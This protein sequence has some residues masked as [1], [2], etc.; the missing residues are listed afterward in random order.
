MASIGDMVARLGVDNSGFT[1]G[2][3]ASKSS[4]TSWAGSVTGIIAGAAGALAG[5]WSVGESVAS[6]RGALEA[7]QKLATVLN[8]T[9]NAAG[10]SF[11]QI[12]EY[13]DGLERA[14]NIDG[15]QAL[16]AAAQLAAFG[17]ITGD[18]FKRTIGAAGDLSAALGGDLGANVAM[19]GKSLNDP[20]A[21]LAKLEKAGVTFTEQ[22]RQQIKTMQKAGDLAGAQA[23]ILDQ[24]QS[25]YGGSAEAL[26]TPYAQLTRAIGDVGE[27]VGSA[28]APS[29][30]VATTYLVGLL[31]YVS[32]GA[33]TFADF[34]IEA[35]V[36]LSHMG[37]IVALTMTQWQLFFV[38]IGLDAAHFFTETIPG[39]LDWFGENWH[40]V[41]MTTANFAATIFENIGTNIRGAWDAVMAYLQGKPLNFNWKPLTEGFVSAIDKLPEIPDRLVSDFERGLQ[42]DIEAMTQNLGES[43]DK[44]RA[45]LAAKYNPQSTTSAIVPTTPVEPAAPTAKPAELKASFAGT[46]EAASILLR[47]IGGGKS[48]EQIAQK[49][50]T[51]QQ[52]TL[53]AVKDNKPAGNLQPATLGT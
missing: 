34:G 48:M 22:Q 45:E 19:L 12:K 51:V 3:A 2:L 46:Q 41:L 8:N 27:M 4:L 44:Q 9:G 28:L 50:L 26:A 14:T 31:D 13:T 23:V 42:G 40:R 21:G 39:Y 10:L 15:D 16:T 52:Q 35:A 47:G 49:Q 5:M 30:D 7:Q 38:T 25:K 6:F 32:S 20:A 24:I 1:K 36:V 53:A 33:Q 18:A 17:T 11:D 43:M 29:I 37:E